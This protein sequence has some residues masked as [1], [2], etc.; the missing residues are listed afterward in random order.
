MPWSEMAVLVRSGRTSIPALRRGL[1]GAGVPV[2]VASDETPLVR[3]PAVRPLLDALRAA[4]NLDN[5]DPDDPDH[6]DP[7]AAEGLLVSPMAGLDATDVRALSRALRERDK[8]VAREEPPPRPSPYLL[9]DAVLDGAGSS[10]R[11]GAADPVARRAPR[12][13]LSCE[14]RGRLLD[15]GARWRRFSGRSGP[16]PAARAAALRGT[17]R[18]AGRGCANRDLDASARSSRPPPAPRSSAVT[19]ASTAFLATLAPRRSRPTPWPSGAST[20]SPCVC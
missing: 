3:E 8:Q 16:A 20:A 6:L 10:A 13:R 1:A 5:D 12:C 15:D 7:M 19:P 18:G 4:V 11:A 2:E 14:R 9:R 17:A